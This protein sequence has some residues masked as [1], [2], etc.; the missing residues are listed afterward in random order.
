MSKRFPLGDKI[1]EYRSLKERYGIGDFAPIEVAIQIADHLEKES[2]D[3]ARDGVERE[4]RNEPTSS[5]VERMRDALGKAGEQFRFY[6]REH[7][8]KAMAAEQYDPAETAARMAK[9]KTNQ[10]FAEMCE[11][12]LLS[13]SG[14]RE[15]EPKVERSSGNVFAD[16]GLPDADKLLEVAERSAARSEHQSAS[17]GREERDY[18]S[19]AVAAPFDH[20]KRRGSAMSTAQQILPNLVEELRAEAG[21]SHGDGAETS[22]E[23]IA[24]ARLLEAHVILQTWVNVSADMSADPLP[25][26][27]REIQDDEQALLIRAREWCRRMGQVSAEEADRFRW[28]SHDW[29][30]DTHTCRKC[31][32]AISTKEACPFSPA[33]EQESPADTRDGAVAERS[34]ARSEPSTAGWLPISTAPKQKVIL[35]WALTDTDTGNWK[36]A[37]GYWM[38]GYG[39]EPGDWYWDGRRLTAYD[40]QPT[41]WQELP[42][43]PLPEQE[44]AS[45]ALGEPK[46]SEPQSDSAG[47][48]DARTLEAAA[49]NYVQRVRDN[50]NL[51]QPWQELCDAVDRALTQQGGRKGE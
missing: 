14:E 45:E 9:Y 25:K 50:G 8:E 32:A 26:P 18:N 13:L 51:G 42:D 49:I 1:Q 41:H 20:N 16:L 44:G 36:M 40:V 28:E 48:L 38:P 19:P 17:P 31:G 39:D 35:L 10:Q 5:D 15:G 3:A 30:P 47:A 11:A 2:V 34:A 7:R 24:A 23:W 43:S 6:E 37:T 33:P 46:A 4:A 29:S 12:A 27:L 22:L 21:M